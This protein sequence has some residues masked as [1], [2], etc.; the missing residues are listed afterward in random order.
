LA[1]DA[2]GTEQAAPLTV[3]VAGVGLG[4]G[5]ENDLADAAAGHSG[6]AARR[7][8]SATAAAPPIKP[9][10]ESLC[11]AQCDD[12]FEP[13]GTARPLLSMPKASMVIAP[14]AEHDQT[15]TLTPH[16]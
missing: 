16:H 6:P 7:G 10:R 15:K 14:K 11:Q 8:P 9:R 3:V 1:P 13:G 5:T 12:N 4:G 2:S